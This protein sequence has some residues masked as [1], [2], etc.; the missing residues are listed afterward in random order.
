MP[1]TVTLGC[2]LPSGLVLT[3]ANHPLGR[4]TL[5]GTARTRQGIERAF[6]PGVPADFWDAWLAEN[7]LFPAL[8]TG[9]VY[10]A[11]REKGA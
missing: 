9:A 5:G 6:T 4:V 1:D 2:T 3:V 7:R 10:E 8:L 11:S